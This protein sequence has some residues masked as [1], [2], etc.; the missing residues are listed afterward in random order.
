MRY[1]YLIA[2]VCI[3][4]SAAA[5]EHFPRNTFGESKTQW[6]TEALTTLSEAPIVP[7]AD[8]QTYRFLWLRSFRPEYVVRVDHDS[9]GTRITSKTVR[10]NQLIE[11]SKEVTPEAWR[12]FL[13][14][15][16]AQGLWLT[17]T[18]DKREYAEEEL[19]RD[20]GLRND[21]VVTADGAQWVIEASNGRLYHAADAWSPED[22]AIYHL[23]VTLLKLAGVAVP[24]DEFF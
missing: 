3:A 22:G 24:E 10:D 17:T 6:Y 2:L 11:E 23:G 13:L 21:I 19:P 18:E 4:T 7:Q 14:E 1:R 20:L 12:E 15:V 16:E 9:D 8:A 5:A